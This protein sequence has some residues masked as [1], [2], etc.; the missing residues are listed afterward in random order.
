MRPIGPA[1]EYAAR[2]SRRARSH[3]M[4]NTESGEVGPCLTDP[5]HE[6][7]LDEPLVT[8]RYAVTRTDIPAMIAALNPGGVM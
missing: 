4:S 6:A 7:A 5:A 3:R 8:R 2:T 1:E